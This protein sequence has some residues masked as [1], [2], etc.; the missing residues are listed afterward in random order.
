MVA[1]NEDGSLMQVPKLI[2]QN[3]EDIRRFWDAKN[4]KKMRNEITVML[5]TE[6]KEMSFDAMLQSIEGDR[7]EL[8]FWKTAW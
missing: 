3:N 7:F 5:N 4:L 8:G 1:K 2:F 6:V